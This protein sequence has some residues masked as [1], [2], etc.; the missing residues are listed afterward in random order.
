MKKLNL[1]SE[2]GSVTIEA[3]ISLSAFMFAIVT[4]LTIVNVCTVQAR[5]SNALN[6]TAKEISQYSY[7]YSLTGLN[8]SMAKLS[9]AGIEDTQEIN[10]VMSDINTVF[11]EIEGLG[12]TGNMSIDNIEDISN[13]WNGVLNSAD[14]IK[15]AGSSLENTI[16]DIAKD[17]KNLMFGI[18]KLAASKTMDLATSRLVAAPLSKVMCK[19]H[20]VSAK[21]GSTDSYLKQ[22]GVVPSANGSYIDGLDFSN[23]SIFPSGSNEITVSVSYD[24]KVIALLP[25]NFE[26]H[27]VQ[28]AITHGWLAGESSYQGNDDLKE[29][30]VD[31]NT[32]WT[33]ATVKERSEYIR[34]LAMKDFSKEGYYIVAKQNADHIMFNPEKNEFVMSSSVNPLW[35]ADGE[36]PM[37]LDDINEDEWKK[38]INKICCQMTSNEYG[39]QVEI[40]NNKDGNTTYETVESAGAKYKLVLTIPEDEGLKEKME[41]IIAASDTDGVTIE[42]IS[43]YGNG[44]SKTVA[45]GE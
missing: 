16:S 44:A 12:N 14:S 40:K 15:N 33:D 31:N 36:E 41:Q 32:L 6:I 3:T 27:F 4:I 13:A 24:V 37:K 23:S 21:G 11:N 25:I 34:N 8:D 2:S 10:S 20:L 39:N 18:A 17:P 19:K 45:A 26:F 35:T 43:N 22:L 9:E 7:L 5:V 30:Y 42:V 28:T 29:K 1:K 38:Q